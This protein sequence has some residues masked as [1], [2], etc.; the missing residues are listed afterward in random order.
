MAMVNRNPPT[1]TALSPAVATLIAFAGCSGAGDGQVPGISAEAGTDAGAK[2]EGGANDAS[3]A[4]EAGTSPAGEEGMADG[5]SDAPDAPMPRT[6]CPASWT[7]TLACGGVPSGV[8]PDF[9]PNVVV[10]A[11]S[12][13][14]SAIQNQLN[15]IYSKMDAD[16]FDELGYALLFLPGQYDLDVQVG[17]YTHVIGLGESPDDVTITG[18]VRAKADWL[19][20]DNATCNFWR[21]VENLAVVPT[22]AIDDGT[23]VWATSQGTALRRVHVRG[24]IVLEDNGGWASGG[25]IAD[26]KIDTEINS[27]SQQQYL[28]RNVDLTNW[29]GSNWNM[30]FVGDGQPPSGTWP[31]PPYSVVQATPVVREKPFLYVD[32]G[33]NYFVMVPALKRNAAGS[34]WGA[35]PPGSPVPPG[36]PLSI[37]QFYIAKPGVDTATTLNAALAA[38]KHLLLTPGGYS[39]DSPIAVTKPDT[40]VLGIGVPVITP[41][42]GTAALT[43]ADV[44][45]V[46]IAG[47]LIQAGA[48]SSPTLVEV[49][50]PGSSADH[51]TNPTQ[52]FDVNCRIGGY[53]AGTAAVCLTVNSDDVILDNSWLWRADHGTGVGWTANMSTSGIVVNGD[54]VTAYALFSEHHQGF[55]T[56]WNGNGG[57]VYFYQSEMPYDPP[58]Q[59][60]WM[61]SPSEN[62]Y[63]SYKV[64]ADVRTHAAI[65]LGVY[66]FFDSGSI[67]A[68][69]AIET[70]TGSGIAMHH[71]MTFTSGNGGIDDIVN[72]TG[73]AATA[74]S[75]E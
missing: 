63:A 62:G 19:G 35:D 8:S 54:D 34:S 12:M 6:N 36:T 33:G 24:S 55:Q 41:T 66:S 17:F 2:L 27:G 4:V 56:L 23:D 5:A 70:P 21:T 11:P 22:A 53:A 46:S 59:A 49:G 9:G 68:A 26:S 65:G 30:V 58:N 57:A 7:T 51:S 60:A 14:T 42:N 64:S 40:V 71:M 15:T 72:G 18:A 1:R 16:Q 29:Q 37:D 20:N 32:G 69:N 45:G 47:L 39:L 3:G 75:S 25:F 67:H 74:Y 28:T 13:A 48:R 52:L 73:G 31:K 10:F 50:A 61:E 43:V 38:G 44:D